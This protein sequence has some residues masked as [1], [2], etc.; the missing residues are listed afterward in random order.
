MTTSNTTP[1]KPEWASYLIPG[2]KSVEA[3]TAFAPALVNHVAEAVHLDHS[4]AA[5]VTITVLAELIQFNKRFDPETGRLVAE[6]TSHAS[7][8]RGLIGA[9]QALTAGHGDKEQGR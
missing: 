7:E 8:L 4:Q 3:L 9:I 6:S 1:P 5:T 2:D